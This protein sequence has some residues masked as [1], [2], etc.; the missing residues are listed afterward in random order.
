MEHLA[1][2]AIWG[3]KYVTLL[4]LFY[5]TAETLITAPTVSVIR[6]YTHN[7]CVCRVC[8]AVRGSEVALKPGDMD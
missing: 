4:D 2:N 3:V 5:A 7:N 8:K 1:S 6:E